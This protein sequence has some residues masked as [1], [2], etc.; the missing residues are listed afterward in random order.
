MTPERGPLPP[1]TD[2]QKAR[3]SWIDFDSAEK[4]SRWPIEQAMQEGIAIGAAAEVARLAGQ[5]VRWDMRLSHDCG[6]TWSEWFGCT[7]AT[8]ERYVCNEDMRKEI[9]S[10][11]V[12]ATT[13]AR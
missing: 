1:L 4:P 5:A 3:C 6:E 10:L 11:G 7:P 8:F 9:R 2:E 12:I 13:S